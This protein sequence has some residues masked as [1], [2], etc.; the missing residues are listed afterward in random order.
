MF[1]SLIHWR[2]GRE[3][4]SVRASVRSALSRGLNER[5]GKRDW[6]ADTP[7]RKRVRDHEHFDYLLLSYLP[8]HGGAYWFREASVGEAESRDALR[9]VSVKKKRTKRKK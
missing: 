2:H 9:R 4:K 3:W 6:F 1:T 7:S 8:R 5:F